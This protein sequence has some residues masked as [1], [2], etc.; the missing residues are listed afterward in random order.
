MW[1][2]RDEAEQSPFQIQVFLGLVPANFNSL[3][4]D[5]HP[6]LEGVS[7][8]VCAGTRGIYIMNWTNAQYFETFDQSR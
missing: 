2:G 5:P 3:L 6:D 4:P 8:F 7:H 1:L